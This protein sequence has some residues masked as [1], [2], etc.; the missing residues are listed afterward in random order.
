MVLDTSA[1]SRLRSGDESV[2]GVLAAAEV[3]LVPTVVIGELEAGFRLGSREAD[4]RMRLREFL[5]EPFVATVPVSRDVAERYG[6]LFAEL[7]TAGTPVPVN[8]VWIAAAALDAGGHLVTFDHDFERFRALD[9][10][11]LG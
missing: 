9:V 6:E 10:T 8:D 7:R 11:V 5:E 4:N 1:Y 3:V 2:I